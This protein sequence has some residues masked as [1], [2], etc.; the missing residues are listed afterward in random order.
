M[1]I[2]LL[3]CYSI[4]AP[5]RLQVVLEDGSVFLQILKVRILVMWIL[6]MGIVKLISDP[7]GTGCSI[8]GVMPFL[9]VGMGGL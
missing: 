3:G 1:L 7:V 9:L 8:V 2:V 4:Q 6:F 5:A